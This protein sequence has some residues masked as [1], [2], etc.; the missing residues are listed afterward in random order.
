VLG[1]A[2]VTALSFSIAAA[3]GVVRFSGLPPGFG[4]AVL[5]IALTT[6]IFTAVF[7]G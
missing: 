7:L 5:D 2:A 6:I 1:P 3:F 4:K